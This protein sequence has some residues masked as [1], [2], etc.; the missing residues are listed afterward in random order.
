MKGE[1][2]WTFF[3]GNYQYS[4][5]LWQ[6]EY[7]I[8]QDVEVPGFGKVS[9]TGK[10]YFGSPNDNVQIYGL[11]SFIDNKTL[12]LANASEVGNNLVENPSGVPSGLKLI[13]T[14]TYLSGQPA[15]YLFSGTEN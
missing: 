2:A 12:Y 14:V 8:G 3:A 5:V 10:F 13:K 9:H 7:P 4:P 1:P 6:K 11:G 15:F